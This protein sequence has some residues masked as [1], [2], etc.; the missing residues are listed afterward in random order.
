MR[1]CEVWNWIHNEPETYSNVSQK[2][3]DNLKKYLW[4]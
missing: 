3:V 2:N 1:L 4:I